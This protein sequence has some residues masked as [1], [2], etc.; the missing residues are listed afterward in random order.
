M[1]STVHIYLGV[2][3]EHVL[4]I[5]NTLANKNLYLERARTKYLLLPGKNYWH[6]WHSEKENRARGKIEETYTL[7]FSRYGLS[8][9]SCGKPVNPKPLP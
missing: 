4:R 9:F 3:P 8:L 7:S 6:D 5:P 2:Y 1:Y